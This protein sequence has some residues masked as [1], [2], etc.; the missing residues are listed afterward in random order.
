MTLE[1]TT[2][3]NSTPTTEKSNGN[4]QTTSDEKTLSA[5]E[6]Q[7]GRPYG[8]VGS[9]EDEAPPYIKRLLGEKPTPQP[10]KPT[11]PVF[12]A[13]D[14]LKGIL[15]SIAVLK[16]DPNH[17]E[18]AHESLVA[19]FLGTLGYEKHRDIKYQQGRVD[20]SLWD[21]NSLLVI[22][23]VKKDWNLSLYNNPE[24]VQQ[25]Y[26]YSLDAGSRYVILTNG[27]YYAVFDR[28][29]G[30]S[31]TSNLIGEFRLTTL[32]EEDLETIRRISR[33]NLLKPNLEEL[34]RYLSE[35]F[36]K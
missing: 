4:T 26:R 10:S 32:Q 1:Q 36:K 28:L 11:P 13:P 23:E 15:S 31:T 30:L 20:I 34:F 8:T 7:R 25:A 19:D 21:G 9:L 22:V 27:D 12:V 29:K 35:S 14:F 6:K 5:P 3:K 2:E 17:Q 33:D 24:A 18:P 16:A